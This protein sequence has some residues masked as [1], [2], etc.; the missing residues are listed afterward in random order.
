MV[1]QRVLIIHNPA[2]QGGEST[3]VMNAYL[4]FL[5]QRM[6]PYRVYTT[7]GDTDTDLLKSIISNEKFRAISIVGGDGTINLALNGLPELETPIHIIPAGSGNDFA[8]M[9]YE[10]K[11][12]RSIFELVLSENLKTKEVDVWKCNSKRFINGFGA[13]FDGAVANSMV[14]KKY[15]ISSKIKYWVE[16]IRHILFYQSQEYKINGMPSKIFMMAVANGQVY[17][18]DFKIA[19]QATINDQLLDVVQVKK[20]WVPLRFFYLPFLQSGN[21]LDK[22]ILDFYRDKELLIQ[23]EF[24]IPAH[25]DGEPLLEKEYKIMHEGVLTVLC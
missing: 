14:G 6:V 9:V 19:P 2:A 21:H 24:D 10:Q 16:I 1:T 13:G 20:L 23:S 25:I 3:S 8:K 4:D 15:W 18:G 11:S 17:G 12:T 22:N 7:N 5:N